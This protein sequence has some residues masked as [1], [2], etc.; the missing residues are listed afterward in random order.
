MAAGDDPNAAG[1]PPTIVSAIPVIKVDGTEQPALTDAIIAIEVSQ[2]NLGLAR[3]EARFENW[4]TPPGGGRPGFMFF[5]GG[6]ISFGKKLEVSMGG[7]SAAAVVF[8]GRI[9]AIEARFHATGVP[10][11]A[12]LADDLLQILRMTRR[13][14]T[15]EDSTDADVAKNIA[16]AHGWKADADATGPTHKVLVQVA[17]SDLAFLRERAAAIDAQVWIEDQT[18]KFKSRKDRDGG[19]VKLKL[20]VTLSRFQVVAD[21]AHQVTSVHAHGYDRSGKKDF[22]GQAEASILS[23][24]ARGAKLG[25]DV[26]KDALGERKEH[27]VDRPLGSDEEATAVAEADLKARGRS[28]VRCRGETSGTP[29]LKIGSRVAV[30][31]VGPVFTGTYVATQVSHLYDRDRG[32]M[33]RFEGER[34]AVGAE[35]GS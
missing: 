3:C 25:S 26:L 15:Y 13:T 4:G 12:V 17:Q 11:I 5:D 33:T 27:V 18:L 35:S 23:S 31:G 32:F 6:V 7:G 8:T 34:P 22:D 21:L 19:D 20:G 30:D 1:G 2:D 9:T 29:A 16:S 10:E 24:E 14:A 28:F